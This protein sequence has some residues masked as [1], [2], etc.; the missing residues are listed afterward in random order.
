MNGKI[1]YEARERVEPVD[2]NL[3]LAYDPILRSENVNEPNIFVHPLPQY[4]HRF[5]PNIC[6]NINVQ[7]SISATPS[8]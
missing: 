3:F 4:P 6:L 8:D 2:H 5:T 7:V 1:I